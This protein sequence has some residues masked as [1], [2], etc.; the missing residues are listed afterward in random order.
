M[1][2]VRVELELMLEIPEDLDLHNAVHQFFRMHADLPAQEILGGLTI[3]D[4]A[5]MNPWESPAF[6]RKPWEDEDE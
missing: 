3:T 2:P 4:V 6:G 1:I 5:R